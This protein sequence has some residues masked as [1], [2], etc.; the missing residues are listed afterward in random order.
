MMEFLKRNTLKKDT[1]TFAFAGRTAAKVVEMRDREFQGTKWEDTP[2]LTASFDDPVSIID[3]VK[4]A[5]VIVNGAG[6]YMLTE[7]ECLVDACIWC[8][9]DYVDISAE[10]PWS[11]RLKE[12]HKYALDAGVYVVPS[13]A[14]QGG[15]PDLGTYLCAKKLKE[16]FGESTRS[17]VCYVSGG[18]TACGT[19]GGVLRTRATMQNVGKTGKDDMNNPFAMGGFVP[20]VDRNGIKE[21]DIQQGTGVVTPRVRDEDLDE[22]LAKISE[23]RKLGIWRAPYVNAWFDTRVVRRSNALM[24]DLGNAPFGIT[25]NFQEFALLPAE[26]VAAAKKAG[27]ATGTD[28]V[29]GQYGLE[30]EELQELLEQEN[31]N[32]KDGE[33]PTMESMTD[34]WTGFFFYAETPTGN[35]VKCSFVGSDGYYET[36]RFAINT[37]LAL[38]FDREKLP[39]RG[40]VLTPSVAAGTCLAERLIASGVKFKMGEWMESSDLAPPDIDA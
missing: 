7:G 14:C 13:A 36:A 28:P 11:M 25:L 22:E 24:A 23:D 12:L 8:K 4:S 15:Y 35:G 18:G 29:Y 5:H 39:F 38:R 26:N 40:G 6:P 30:V 31:K 27:A 2:V 20:L 16:D 19:S 9:C 34:A 17:A 1:F 33:G 21:V 3:L 32:F 37:A 10:I